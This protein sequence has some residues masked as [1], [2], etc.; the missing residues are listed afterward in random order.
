M[1]G[2][3]RLRRS[4]T[5]RSSKRASSVSVGDF[6]ARPPSVFLEEYGATP[7]GTLSKAPETHGTIDR[8][9]RSAPRSSYRPL[10]AELEE[11]EL[12]EQENA[13]TEPSK[14]RSFSFDRKFS[15]VP[16]RLPFAEIPA[17]QIKLL[18]S[19]L[20][21]PD[22]S[23]IA[24]SAKLP[25]PPQTKPV[26]SKIDKRDARAL[27]DR[28]RDL[29]DL[30]T[31]FERSKKRASRS[32]PRDQPSTE[33]VPIEKRIPKA[34]LSPL[35]SPQTLSEFEDRSQAGLSEPEASDSELVDNM[36]A[37][38][39]IEEDTFSAANSFDEIADEIAD[40]K[41]HD[42]EQADDSR[43][44][45]TDKYNAKPLPPLSDADMLS[46]YLPTEKTDSQKGTYHALSTTVKRPP[47]PKVEPRVLGTITSSGSLDHTSSEEEDYSEDDTES[48]DSERHDEVTE[49]SVT[50]GDLTE[51]DLTLRDVTTVAETESERPRQVSYRHAPETETGSSF[52][53]SRSPFIG[54]ATSSG[55]FRPER[56]SGTNVGD[57]L[58][59][60]WDRFWS[61]DMRKILRIIRNRFKD[62]LPHI[63]RFL[64]HVVAFWGGVTYI[65]RALTAFI[66]IM[67]RDSRVRELLHRLGWAST[68]TL[69]V[70]MSLCA[71]M[72]QASLQFYFLMRDRIIPQLRRVIPK[73]YYKGVVL[74]LRAARHSPWALVMGPFSLTAAIESRKIPDPY[75]LHNKFGVPED[76][77]SFDFGVGDTFAGSTFFSSRSR[78][79]HGGN[80][81]TSRDTSLRDST[82][83]EQSSTSAQDQLTASSKTNDLT[84]SGYGDGKENTRDYVSERSVGDY[85]ED[86]SSVDYK[87]F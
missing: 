77:T 15:A 42:F 87:E 74:L 71:M 28:L 36:S 55:R 35:P 73:C 80:T 49:R 84:V 1:F 62:L 45:T 21:R 6:I 22:Y 43:D 63:R 25:L 86:V 44:A 19:S 48:L 79:A 59:S 7:R 37:S 68:T 81:Q 82:F 5:R 30:E 29:K 64:A 41:T 56:L 47:V 9:Y 4:K 23:P 13:L 24:A 61:D 20:F 69:R 83:R 85:H 18:S 51:R 2:N 12:A 66:R 76:D 33:E 26:R 75:Y 8:L 17:R 10:Q 50:V 32:A 34:H 52:T 58:V 31:R 39:S 40:E 3:L 57:A 14:K 27:S 16:R 46:D 70:F 67:Q 11:H 54:L 38:S 65:R 72:L 53:F 60:V 78:S